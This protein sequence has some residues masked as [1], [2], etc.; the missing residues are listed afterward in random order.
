M[1]NKHKIIVNEKEFEVEAGGTILQALQ[2]LNIE[3]PYFCYHEKLSIAGNCRMCLVEV[4]PG[5]P[6]PIASCAMPTA[7]DMVISTESEMVKKARNGVM[8]LLLINHPLDCPICDQG[9]ECDLQDQAFAFGKGKSRYKFPKRA[10]NEKNFGPIVSTVM[11]RCIHC[12]RCVRF[13]DEVAGVPALGAVGRGENME[14]VTYNNEDIQSEL[15]GNLVDLCPVGALTS[16]PYKFTARSWELKKTNSI[17]VFDSLGSNICIHSF[18][19]KVVRVLPINREDINEVWLGDKSRYAI[20]GLANQRLDHPY[21]RTNGKLQKVSWDNAL[22]A[23][24]TAINKSENM[25]AIA[26][27]MTDCESMTAMKDLMNSLNFNNYECRPH[28]VNIPVDNKQAWKFNSRIAGIEE[29]DAI[30]IIGSNPRW[31][32][33]VLNARIRKKHLEDSIPIA[34]IGESHD[35]TY[36]YYHFGN[37]SKDINKLADNNNEF[38]KKLANAKKPMVILGM[39]FFSLPNYQECFDFLLTFIQNYA[40]VNKEWNGWNI[41]HSNASSVGGLELGFYTGNDNII[42]TQMSKKYDVLYI[43]GEDNL[44][45]NKNDNSFIIYQGSHG[46]KMAEIADVILPGCAYT[47]KYATY[48]NTE[49]IMQKTCQAVSAPGIAKNDWEIISELAKLLNK[50]LP[51]NNNMELQN[52]MTEISPY[53]EMEDVAIQLDNKCFTQKRTNK[54][55]INNDHAINNIINNYYMT[56]AISRSSLTMAECTKAFIKTK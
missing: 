43:L 7:N 31:E 27:S 41:L 22:Q 2:N 36:P 45:I 44:P 38:I 34:L 3:V 11:N 13:A 39:G 23:V 53:F 14:I 33:P 29:A 4:Q 18:N 16:K 10:V 54:L 50:P 5:P 1:S 9:G 48:L 19:N 20:D 26:G 24:V 6:K 21:L 40:F 51:Y 49:G 17:D 46:D 28:G 8:E 52:R 35:L 15:S 12:T 56:D 55:I 25:A 30:L 37:N 47:E 32:A 42:N